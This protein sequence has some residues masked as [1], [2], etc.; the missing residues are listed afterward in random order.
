LFSLLL[1]S[2]P[3]HEDFL[4]AELSEA[5][6]VGIVEEDGR[7]RAF[8]DDGCDRTRL[9]HRFAALEPELRHEPSTDWE[10]VSRDSWPSLLIGRR[11]FLVTPWSDE[12]TPAGRLRLEIYPGMACG[13][14]R[15]PATQLCLEA[16]EESIRP[17]DRVLD[18]GAGS[19][20]LSA[21]AI[22][23]GGG[24]V[25]GCDVDHDAVNIARERVHLPLFT[26]SA[27]AI[28]SNWADVVVANINS[29]TIEELAPE[30]AR[31]RKPDSTLILSGFPEWD[32]PDCVAAKKMLAREE[33]RCLIC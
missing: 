27:G 17:G 28:S 10:Q 31:V 19:G 15:H 11:F 32:L 2:L 22:L 14:G 21:A 4:T 29:A 33:W 13:T 3:E 8:F 7:L 16:L 26:G 1:H 6:T 5:G 23:L 12:P 20:I 24:I 9:L 25:V 18:V 30:L